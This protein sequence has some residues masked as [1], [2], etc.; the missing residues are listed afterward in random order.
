M[1][2]FGLVAQHLWRPDPLHIAG[3]V[4]RE[5]GAHVAP[6]GD[7][8][9]SGVAIDADGPR[10]VRLVGHFVGEAQDD[11]ASVRGEAARPT[12]D[13]IIMRA[14]QNRRAQR[15]GG[16]G[17]GP[18]PRL[19]G[20]HWHRAERVDCLEVRRRELALPATPDRVPVHDRQ[21]V[22]RAGVEV[23]YGRH[24]VG[25]DRLIQPERDGLRRLR[26]RGAGYAGLRHGRVQARARDKYGDEHS[27]ER[28]AALFGSIRHL[29][30]L[31]GGK[32]SAWL[33]GRA[34]T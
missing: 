23:A 10:I 14:G 20:D 32:F 21:L 5:D 2:R 16:V 19:P 33:S 27:G 26:R 3:G 11:R 15:P 4:A 28:R 7:V 6:R 17:P 29:A 9:G 12:V 34:L 31:T 18:G 1:D 22:A 30:G 8:V 24:V 25:E 13:V